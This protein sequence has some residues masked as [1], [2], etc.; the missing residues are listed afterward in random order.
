MAQK[1]TQD[2]RSI[3][4]ISASGFDARLFALCAD[5]T[6]WSLGTNDL[7]RGWVQLPPIPG[8]EL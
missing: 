5:D 2:L 6:I 4:Q 8:T 7:G 1:A 3:V